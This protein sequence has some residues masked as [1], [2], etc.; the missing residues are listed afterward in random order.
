M[1]SNLGDRLA[2][3]TMARRRIMEWPDVVL[4]AQSPVY[5]TEPVGVQVQ[6]RHLPF[7]NAVLVVESPWDAHAWYKRLHALET[8]LGRKRGLDRYA[9]RTI[10]LDIVCVG[11]TCVQSGG[12]V[13]PHP[14]WR[15]RRFVVRPLADIRPNLVIPGEG[16]TVREMLDALPPTPKVALFAKEW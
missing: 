2:A 7:L 13:I 10:D 3:L 15:E 4:V 11:H 14:H 8:K 1:G 9:P 16:R 5:E 12:L 6:Y